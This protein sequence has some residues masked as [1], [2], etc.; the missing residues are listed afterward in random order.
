MPDPDLDYIDK[1]IAATL[2]RITRQW[3]V[4]EKVRRR[5]VDTGKAQQVLAAMQNTLSELRAIRRL[6]EDDMT[7]A[8]V[9]SRL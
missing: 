8:K 7:D 4:I 6:I 5:K 1:Q 9:S 3:V 2:Q